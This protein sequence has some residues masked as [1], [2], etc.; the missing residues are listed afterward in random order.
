MKYTLKVKHRFGLNAT[1][2]L[3]LTMEVVMRAVK[4]P[5]LEVNATNLDQFKSLML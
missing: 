1:Y 2:P 4:S 3:F 5:S